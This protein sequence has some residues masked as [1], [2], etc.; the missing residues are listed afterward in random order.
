MSPAIGSEAG[1]RPAPP[2]AA[3]PP[4]APPLDP[5]DAR[6]LARVLANAP[7]GAD[8]PESLGLSGPETADL[9]LALG[10]AAIPAGSPIFDAGAPRAPCEDTDTLA[11]LLEA[12]AAGHGPATAWLARIVARRALEPGHLWQALGLADRGDLRFLLERHFPTLAARNVANMRWK[13]FFFRELCA[14]Q[15]YVACLVP[16]CR[17]CSSQPECFGPEDAPA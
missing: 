17:D 12:H 5:H 11:G 8:L 16:D 2:F 6:L 13:K 7:D 3:W 14:G 4:V 1:A 15:G 9:L 10:R